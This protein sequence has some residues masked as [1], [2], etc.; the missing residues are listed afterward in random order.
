MRPAVLALCSL[1]LLGCADDRTGGQA[2]VS[3]VATTT[4]VGDLA[5][6]VAGDRATVE[7][8]LSP[9]ADPHGYEP[10]PSDSRAIADAAVVLRSGGELDGWLEGLID[11]AG[12]DAE[13]VSAGERT[14]RGPDDDPHW[15]QDP[16]NAAIAVRTIRDALSA[17][18]PGGRS[19]YSRNADRY[20]ARLRALDRGVAECI[21][22][23]PRADRKLVTTHDA[24]GLYARRYGLEVVG[25]VIPS[26]SS[27]AQPS[28]GATA[29]LA[30]QIRAERV[31]AIFPESSLEPDL[32]R[33]I[34]RETGATVGEPLWADTLGPEGSGGATYID[35]IASN[36]EAIVKG[37][38]GGSCALHSERARPI[39]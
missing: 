7:Q 11:A 3:V 22:R 34:A 15:W 4:Q 33:A 21:G 2:G 13:V 18:D 31:K 19:S 20:L 17:A 5:R 26:L 37:L 9:N 29:R 35:S 1:A 23:V 14:D 30:A 27:Q 28:S 25:A 32:E 6:Q 8:I 24:L 39:R 16:R 10:R 38:T 36:T 12:G